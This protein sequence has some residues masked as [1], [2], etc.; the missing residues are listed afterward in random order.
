MKQLRVELAE[1][2]GR[3]LVFGFHAGTPVPP[4]KILALLEDQSGKYRFTPDYRL[5]VRLGRMTGEEV[6]RTA[7]KQLQ[8]FL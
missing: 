2:D 3:Q 7:K 8:V 6:L 4:D 1:Y 5:S